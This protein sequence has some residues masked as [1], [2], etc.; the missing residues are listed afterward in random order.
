LI[1][2]TKP[3]NQVQWP[4]ENVTT[5]EQKPQQKNV[6]VKKTFLCSIKTEQD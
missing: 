2:R 6:E 3:E 4:Q 5:Q 1:T